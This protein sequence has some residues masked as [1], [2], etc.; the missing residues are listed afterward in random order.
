MS[1]TTWVGVVQGAVVPDLCYSD[2]PNQL[3]FSEG[4]AALVLA[5]GSTT[6]LP[7]NPLVFDADATASFHIAGVDFLFG[8]G[9]VHNISSGI[10]PYTYQALCTRNGGEVV[11]GGQF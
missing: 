7:S 2:L 4:D 11:D 8:D 6:H 3:A 9:S 5:H 1:N 10:N